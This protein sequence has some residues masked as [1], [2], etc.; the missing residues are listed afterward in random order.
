MRRRV[1]VILGLV[2]LT[3]FS[4]TVSAAAPNGAM[5]RFEGESFVAPLGPGG[6]TSAI[7]NV[8]A[9]TVSLYV[10]FPKENLLRLLWSMPAEGARSQKG[11]HV[12]VPTKGMAF[13][14]GVADDG[15]VSIDGKTTSLQFIAADKLD[16]MR[17]EAQRADCA[18][19]SLVPPSTS[20]EP[21][22]GGREARAELMW[23]GVAL[24]MDG[25]CASC[26]CVH[27]SLDIPYWVDSTCCGFGC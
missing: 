4:F 1:P 7:L 23:C 24:I 27:R 3:V 26:Y 5:P 11:W 6:E 9:G 14:L 22:A 2:V 15:K 20:K 12:A 18:A 17:V 21:S 13:D 16:G 25:C 19:T 10:Y 8:S